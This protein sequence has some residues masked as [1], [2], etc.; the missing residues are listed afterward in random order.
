MVTGCLR[1]N[2]LL[3]VLY[4]PRTVIIRR[5]LSPRLQFDPSS[6]A[7]LGHKTAIPIAKPQILVWSR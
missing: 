2:R 5:F 1:A 6:F 4:S 3:A 7:K